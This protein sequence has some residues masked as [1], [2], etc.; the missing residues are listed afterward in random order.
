MVKVRAAREGTNED[1]E[2]EEDD[3]D[4]EEDDDEETARLETKGVAD[5]F[6][7]DDGG[8]NGVV[9]RRVVEEDF[10]KRLERAE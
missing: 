7:K 1:D 3:D 10:L 6:W 9:A 5:G 8:T 2:E 4:D